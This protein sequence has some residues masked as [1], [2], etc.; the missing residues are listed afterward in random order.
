MV[1]YALNLCPCGNHP[2]KYIVA[3]NH[4][5]ASHKTDLFPETWNEGSIGIMVDQH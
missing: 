3:K 4:I 2:W 1:S 5:T